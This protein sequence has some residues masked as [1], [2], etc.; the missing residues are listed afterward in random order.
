MTDPLLDLGLAFLSVSLAGLVAMRLGQPVIPFYILC[1]MLVGPYGPEITLWGMTF[2][3]SIIGRLEVVELMADF[4]VLFLL[5]FLG[6]EFSLKR[7]LQSGRPIIIS[8]FIDL[9]INFPLGLLFGFLMGWS[10]LETLFI[11]GVF[12]MSSSGITTKALIDLKR[13][14]NPE[15]ETILGILVFEDLFIAIFMAVIS[16]VALAGNTQPLVILASI[17]KALLFTFIFVIA[18]RRLRNPIE[19]AMNVESE[20]VFLL[21]LFAFV[22]L[23]AAFAN[24]IGISATLG[25]FLLGL[26]YSETVHARRIAVKIIPLRDLFAAMFFFSFGMLVDYRVIAISMILLIVALPMAIAGKIVSGVLAGTAANTRPHAAVNIGCGIIARG[27]FSIVLA[28]IAA[29]AGFTNVASFT[30]A[31]VLSLAVI[32]PVLMRE[33]EKVYNAFNALEQ[34]LFKVTSAE[35]LPS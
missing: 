21:I 29:T 23:V 1:G 3:T 31:F 20:E 34:R 9:I 16:G 15:S 19:K 30:A 2:S 24:I 35:E 25:A 10:V 27:E 13:I 26:V 14:A 11:A 4:G 22:L 5:L 32:G 7:L 33:S 18:A 12:Y 17:A 28:G 8:G 6:L